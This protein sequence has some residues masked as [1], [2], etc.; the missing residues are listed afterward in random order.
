MLVPPGPRGT[1]VLGFFRDTL[2]FLQRT[3]ER[4]G[5]FAYFRLLH[6]H[7]YLATD[8]EIVKEV[9]ITQQASF[10]RDLGAVILRELVG[11]G[12]ITREEPLHRERRRVLQPA[13]HREQIASY[14]DAMAA[15]ASSAL[16]AWPL[17]Q[18]V[19]MGQAMRA[20][21][22]SII[23]STLFG[24]EFQDR[25]LAVSTILREVVQRAGRIGPF[26]SVC[27][28]VTRAYRQA[29]PNGP[30]LFFAG[31]RAK[32]DTI[33]TPLIDR[34]RGST[35]RDVLSL[36]LALEFEDSAVRNEIV[37]FVLAGH[38]TTATALTWGFYL[39]AK[40]PEIQ[41]QL[42]EES[43][44]VLGDRLP[45]IEDVPNLPFA[46]QVFT[47]VLR[48]YPPVGMFGRRVIK[49]LDLGGYSLPTNATVL[50]SPFITSHDPRYFAEPY[51]FRPERWNSADAIP[52]FAFFPFG[53]GAKMCIGD[54]FAK[55]EGAVI[56]AM[57]AGK[58]RFSW[59]GGAEP[60]ISSRA[61]LQPKTPVVLRAERRG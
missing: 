19:D 56:L 53:G 59:N 28:P 58:L 10:S 12:L 18:E 47:E 44:Q 24:P 36:L 61:T 29:F 4:Y 41:D 20:V 14:V 51:E 16:T 46:G 25:A 52:K 22:L 57:L 5:P 6:Q 17:G 50:L 35:G 40:H 7:L 27:K 9:L 34:R 43:R 37:T 38:E 60:E 30:S 26:V 15:E 11:D 23:G 1:E 48:L 55:V 33:L 13:F 21:T 3:A 54:T 49:P 2:F 39:L 8:A 42:A 32:L 31:P 45:T